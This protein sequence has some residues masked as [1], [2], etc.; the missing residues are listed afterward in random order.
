MDEID[1]KYRQLTRTGKC[2]S[3]GRKIL[4]NKDYVIHGYNYKSNAGT[5]TLCTFCVTNMNRLIDEAQL[6][7]R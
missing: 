2:C 7:R 5:V 6:E 3:C 1:Y 4:A